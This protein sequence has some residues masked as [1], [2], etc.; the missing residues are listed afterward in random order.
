MSR[1]FLLVLLALFAGL[2]ISV[3]AQNQLDGRPLDPDID[4][5]ID[6]FMGSWQ[7]S[8]PYNTHGALV[9]RAILSPLRGDDHL[10]PTSKG[11]VL[12]NI[13]RI[14]RATLDPKA[15]TS[16]VTLNGEQEILYITS[17][18]G[19]ITAGGETAGL[20]DGILVL[21]PEGLEFTIS[22]TEDELLEIYLVNEKVGSGFTPNK[23]M[24]I[25][26]EKTMPYRDVGIPKTHWSHNGK[27]IFGK[28]NGLATLSAI[29]L[30]TFNAMTIGHPHSHGED[31]EEIWT[32]IEGKGIAFLGKEIRWQP[33][34]T[35]YKIPQTDFTPHSNINVTEKPVKYLYISWQP[36]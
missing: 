11:A 8:I 3:S 31:Y 13:N 28:R 5:D 16:P 23:K 14:S 36:K 32:V 9:E 1:T 34:G 7:N 12:R 10:R 21:M 35:A 4:P 26:N 33:P 18:K 6:M 19:T 22:N 27:G 25:V 15:S 20:S 29:T 2:A 17:G 24:T 30:I